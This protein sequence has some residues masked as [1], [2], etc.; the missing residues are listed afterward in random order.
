MICGLKQLFGYDV[1][2]TNGELGSVND[3]YFDDHTWTVRYIVVDTGEWLPGR[4]VLIS[5]EKVVAPDHQEERISVEMTTQEVQSSP[6]VHADLPVSEQERIDLGRYYVW[7]PAWGAIGQPVY[8]A[9]L[10]RVPPVGVGREQVQQGGDANL[11][12]VDEVTGYYI[13]ATDGE[14][15]HAEDFIA[16]IGEWII[17][18]MV[19]DT[20]NWLPGRKV[21][22]PPDAIQ[23][24]SWNEGT[25]EVN[26]SRDQVQES[27]E[28]DPESMAV[29][30]EYE[31]TLHEHYGLEKYWERKGR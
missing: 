26:L 12:S 29:N 10:T 15:G 21:L 5:P 13:G 2:T 4:R 31:K 14:I 9:P 22:I 17:R 8:G 1:V 7:A 25:V 30:R 23:S 18:Y 11:R 16:E 3:L 24:V 6:G 20:R 28:Y 19:V 27:P